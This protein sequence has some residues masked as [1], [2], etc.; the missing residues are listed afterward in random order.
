M[1][2]ADL[3]LKKIAGM[4]EGL[5]A[6]GF[7]ATEL[8][9]A[10]GVCRAM[11]QDKDCTVFFAFTSNLM[12][13][14]LRGLFIEMAKRKM[15]DA[16]VTAGGALDH[17]FIRAHADY[18]IGSFAEDDVGLHKKSVNRLGNILVPNDRYVMFE[19]K[20]KP[21]LKALYEK[22]KMV[23]PREVA[24]EMGRALVGK[25]SFLAECFKNNIPVYCPGITDSALGL[26]M[27]FFK[28][29][30][31]DFAVDVTADMGEMAALVLS[32][33]K[34]GAMILGGGISKHYTIA[35]NLLRGGLDYAVYVTT[36]GEFDGSL[37]GAR[38]RE[39]KSWGK[40]GERAAT[41]TVHC[42]AT[43]AFPLIYSGLNARR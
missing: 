6:T 33:K 20:I 5:E 36:A 4:P 27:H 13:S 31:R 22:K 14:G 7:Q 30:H 37:S 39:A 2:V 25:K 41:A 26:Q 19:R 32:A 28:Q 34:T 15:M 17:D 42:D 10:A 18:E 43:I 16:V 12:A 29:D 35:S 23:S 24:A 21:V 38:A 9:K 1:K 11:L 8:A 3:G 40:I